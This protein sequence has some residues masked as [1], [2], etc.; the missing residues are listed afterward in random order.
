M[1]W[2]TYGSLT[3]FRKVLK[4]PS[5]VG[6]LL[7]FGTPTVFN[8]LTR[9]RKA[10]FDPDLITNRKKYFRNTPPIGSLERESYLVS[11]DCL[12][13]MAHLSLLQRVE[14]IK[15]RWNIEASVGKLRRLYKKHKVGWRRSYYVMKADTVN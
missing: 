15:R 1:V 7:G 9:F 14:T 6:R 12:K 5:A 3:R 10:N 8:F 2:A 11:E 4:G 13:K